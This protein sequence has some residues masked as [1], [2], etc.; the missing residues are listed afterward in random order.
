[1]KRILTHFTFALL[2]I[3]SA[4]YANAAHI[5][6]LPDQANS[7]KLS[8]EFVAAS[9]CS[10]KARSLAASYYNAQILSVEQHGNSCTVVIRVND[11]NGNPPRIITRT[12]PG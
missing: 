12:I 9:Y 3:S 1:M 6:V 2:T 4:P 11:Q 8:T 10:A 7:Q 5:G